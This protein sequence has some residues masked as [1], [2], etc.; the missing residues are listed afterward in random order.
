VILTSGK[1][2]FEL[3][4]YRRKHGVSDTPIIR[5][6]QLYPFPSQQLAAELA[7]YP[8]LK[9]LVWCQEEPR[10]QGAWSYIEP[11]LRE[12]LAAGVTPSYAGPAASA[13]TAPGYHS[14]H[15]ARQAA[16]VSSAFAE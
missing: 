10:N 6:E 15:V 8:N 2:Y 4:E 3:L 16:L 7:R 12:V 5:V 11:R 9:T 13:S 14:A 1:V